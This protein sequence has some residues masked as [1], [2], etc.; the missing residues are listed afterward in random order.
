MRAVV[1]CHFSLPQS[2]SA[3]RHQSEELELLART[4]GPIHPN[5]GAERTDAWLEIC[6]RD[7]L[8]DDPDTPVPTL[9]LKRLRVVTVLRD[10]SKTFQQP[11]AVLD[12][13]E[14]A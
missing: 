5:D 2:S 13:D 10:P 6:I 3:S 11:L 14:E 12:E 4:I 1:Y 8:K 9:G 7:A